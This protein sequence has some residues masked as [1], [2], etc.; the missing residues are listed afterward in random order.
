MDGEDES[1]RKAWGGSRGGPMFITVKDLPLQYREG[2]VVVLDAARAGHPP[3][4]VG[5]VLATI[6]KAAEDHAA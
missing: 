5:D 1:V 2:A 3:L 4:Q 6:R